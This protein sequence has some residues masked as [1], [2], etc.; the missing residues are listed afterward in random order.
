[1]RRDIRILLLD[2]QED[3]LNILIT[4]GLIEEGAESFT[5]AKI[6]KRGRE[7]ITKT[8]DVPKAFLD[9]FRDLYPAGHRSTESEIINTITSFSKYNPQVPLDWDKFLRAA[10]HYV[11]AKKNFAGYAKY[12][13]DK[14]ISGEHQFR[15]LEYLE[16]A[17]KVPVKHYGG[18]IL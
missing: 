18:K 9:A 8:V 2:N 16:I 1:M 12:F 6:T 13:F 17:D 4:K 11:E 3:I 14:V 7:K 15:I 5:N 10:E